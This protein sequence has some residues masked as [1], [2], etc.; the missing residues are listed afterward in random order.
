MGNEETKTIK[1]FIIT[2]CIVIVIIVGIYF[3]T[4]KT[5]NKDASNNNEETKEIDYIN[6][7]MAIVGTMLN[8]DEEE[9]YVMVYDASDENS[10]DYARLVTNFKAK[11]EY[12]RTY[13]VDLSNPLNSKYKVEENENTNVI[14]NKL[15][16][17]KFGKITVLSIKNGNIVKAYENVDAIKKVWKL[18]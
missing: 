7:S 12:V 17:L 13:M 15:N 16:D 6:P 3:L 8:K 14:S 5:V 10:S 1:Q 11:K 2:L 9:Y 4:N 18:D